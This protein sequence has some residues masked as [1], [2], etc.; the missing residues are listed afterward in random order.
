MCLP[1]LKKPPSPISIGGAMVR[2]LI[3]MKK[4]DK[5]QCSSFPRKP[6][7]VDDSLKFSQ[8]SRPEQKKQEERWPLL[9]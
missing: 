2:S 7:A 6:A 1:F 9:F 8:Y 5:R 3:L 4:K